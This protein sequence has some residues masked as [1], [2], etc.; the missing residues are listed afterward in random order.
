[1]TQ[2][3]AL[4]RS[5]KQPKI[6]KQLQLTQ[7]ELQ[8]LST[9]I[10]NELEMRYSDAFTYKQ[11]SAYLWQDCNPEDKESSSFFALN[12]YKNLQRQNNAKIQKLATIQSKLKGLIKIQK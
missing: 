1:M 2:T 4:L 9:H 11:V 8:F 3:P 5:K 10:R 6:K 7:A 12:D